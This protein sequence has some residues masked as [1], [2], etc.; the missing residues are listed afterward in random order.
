MAFYPEALQG[1]AHWWRVIPAIHSEDVAPRK[2]P[3]AQRL[4]RD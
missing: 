1:M 3:F 4:F 2:M